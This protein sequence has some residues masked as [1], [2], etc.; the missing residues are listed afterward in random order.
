M[1]RPLKE[2]TLQLY[3]RDASNWWVRDAAPL[4][5]DYVRTEFWKFGLKDEFEYLIKCFEGILTGEPL[6]SFKDMIADLRRLYPREDGVLKQ[7]LEERLAVDI[8]GEHLS[9]KVGQSIVGGRV[10]GRRVTRHGILHAEWPVYSGEMEERYDN[11]DVVDRI[12][13]PDMLWPDET[14]HMGEPSVLMALNTNVSIAFAQAGIDAALDLIDEGSNDGILRGYTTAQPVDPN[15]AVSGQTLLFTLRL[16]DPAFG[17]SS[18]D[19]PGALAAAGTIDDDI[20]ADNTDTL[21]WCR[22][23]SSNDGAAPLNAHIDGSAGV[24]TFDFVFNT[25]AIVSAATVS[26]TAWTVTQ[27]QGPTAT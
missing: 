13:P 24:G 11:G 19:T 12:P 6:S 22:G 15:V 2:S 1:P 17:G 14:S 18:D 21:V 5:R 20:S 10:V 16:A 7:W 4:N 23:F 8:D 3:A 26:M 27:P 9:G 25:V